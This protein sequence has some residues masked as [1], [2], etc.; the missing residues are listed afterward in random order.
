MSDEQASRR[1]Y[2]VRNQIMKDA[3]EHLQC[4]YCHGRV[5]EVVEQGERGDFCDYDPATDP[6]SFGFPQD[7]TRNARG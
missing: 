2:C 3:G 1:V 7:S 6:M 5:R 4:P